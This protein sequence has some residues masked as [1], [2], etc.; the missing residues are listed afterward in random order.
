MG[1]AMPSDVELLIEA[2]E[3]RRLF[4]LF[5]QKAWNVIEPGKKSVQ[6]WHLDA[7]AEHLQAVIQGDIKRLLVNMP[8]RHGKSSF[9]STLIHPWSWL[10]NPGLRWLCASFGMNLAIRDNLKSRRIIRSPWWQ[11]RWGKLFKLVNDQDAKSKFENDKTGYRMVGSVG[12][13]GTT[14][15]CRA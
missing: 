10:Q 1:C 15:E 13:A 4:K 6:G 2:E 14:G 8:P 5:A 3:C 11:D 7:I 12:S 9:I